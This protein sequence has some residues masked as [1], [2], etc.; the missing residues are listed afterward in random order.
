VLCQIDTVT[1]EVPAW[2]I[3]SPDFAAW[4]G[5]P[6]LTIDSNFTALEGNNSALETLIVSFFPPF[7]FI[8]FTGPVVG[9]SGQIA[10]FFFSQ[11]CFSFA[12]LVTDA[13]LSLSVAPSETPLPA[14]LPLFATGLGALGLLGWRRKR[15]H[16]AA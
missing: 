4:T 3:T 8:G 14:A 12:C 16:A 7:D 10:G 2:N 9:G 13:T 11:H 5:T 6:T 1:G 15:K